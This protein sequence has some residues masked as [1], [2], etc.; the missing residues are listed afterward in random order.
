[1]QSSCVWCWRSGEDDGKCIGS[2]RSTEGLVLVIMHYR[3]IAL[4]SS[5]S[6]AFVGMY[7]AGKA[8]SFWPCTLKQAYNVHRIIPDHDLLSTSLE[9][10]SSDMPMLSDLQCCVAKCPC[11]YCFPRTHSSYSFLLPLTSQN[12]R[13]PSPFPPIP[14]SSP[15]KAYGSPSLKISSPSLVYLPSPCLPSRE[16]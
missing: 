16:I 1:M 11:F 9:P 8:L 13:R 4:H 10:C 7:E 2:G 3:S 6:S 14:P 12:P 15:K 5:G